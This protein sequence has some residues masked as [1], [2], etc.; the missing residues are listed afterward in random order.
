[1]RSDIL[2]ETAS[3]ACTTC[4]KLMVDIARNPRA[5]VERKRATMQPRK[6]GQ[7]I[8]EEAVKS[9]ASIL[10]GSAVKSILCFANGEAFCKYNRSFG[11]ESLKD[12]VGFRSMNA[13]KIA[14]LFGDCL[15]GFESFYRCCP[16][17][18]QLIYLIHRNDV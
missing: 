6:R 8:R 3:I 7:N 16:V 14:P 11:G 1:M 10:T 17:L 4:E 13:S 5:K 9:S 12:V 15:T 2:S 18:D